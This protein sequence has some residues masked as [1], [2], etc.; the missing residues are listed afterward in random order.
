MPRNPL[1]LLSRNSEAVPIP[2][3]ILARRADS[4]TRQSMVKSAPNRL[5][6]QAR[7]PPARPRW[8]LQCNK[9]FRASCQRASWQISGGMQ[10]KLRNGALEQRLW[11]VFIRAWVVAQ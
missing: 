6:L 4:N 8:F 9:S 5:H 1:L 2:K 7:L 3:Q 11:P 10:W